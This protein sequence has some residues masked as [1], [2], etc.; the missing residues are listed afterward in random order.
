M[1]K[2]LIYSL[3]LCLFVVFTP[4]CNDQKAKILLDFEDGQI[5]P[6]VE[7]EYETLGEDVIVLDKEVCEPI[8]AAKEPSDNLALDLITTDAGS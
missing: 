5:L 7:I 3:C 6:D 4:S 8:T 1:I 2:G